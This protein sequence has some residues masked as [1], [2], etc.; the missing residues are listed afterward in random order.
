MTLSAPRFQQRQRDHRV[1]RLARENR[2]RQGAPENRVRPGA[3]KIEPQ[4]GY[5]E[6]AYDPANGVFH[7]AGETGGLGA[8][9]GSRSHATGSVAVWRSGDAWQVCGI[10]STGPV[11]FASLAAAMAAA[12]GLTG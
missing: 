8:E 1:I 11:C 7:R 6:S 9:N 12:Y 2:A 3:Q 4:G 5:A 10:G